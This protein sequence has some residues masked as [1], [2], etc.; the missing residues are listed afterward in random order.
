MRTIES[1]RVPERRSTVR[2]SRVNTL[3]RLCRLIQ[4]TCAWSAPVTLKR[5]RWCDKGD[6]CGG[7][8]RQSL[9]LVR[10]RRNDDV[11]VSTGQQTPQPSA[12]WRVA[13]RERRQRR[14]RPVNEQFAKVSAPS[15]GASEETWFAASGFLPSHDAEASP[16]VSGAVE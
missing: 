13:L 4:A 11:M 8:P 7:P 5:R 14:L 2:L 12:E 3:R 16:K 15:L 10:Q 6:R 1:I 9:Q